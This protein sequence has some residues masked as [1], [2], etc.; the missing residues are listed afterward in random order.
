MV[1]N[2]TSGKASSIP[3]GLAWGA[4]VS[5]SLTLLLA[6]VI[7]V[8]IDTG[9]LLWDNV[10]YG[11]MAMLFISSFA[12]A[13]VSNSKIKR[14]RLMVS[15]MFATVYLG[16]LIAATA[17]FFGGQYHGVGVTTLLVF[18]GSLTSVLLGKEGKRDRGIVEIRG[19][20]R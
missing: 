4:V 5:T 1:I 7:A 11:I 17:L 3:A 16:M 12:G 15:A 8:L 20:T 19:R 10:G 6:V 14:Q 2:N 9:R 13:K 18:C